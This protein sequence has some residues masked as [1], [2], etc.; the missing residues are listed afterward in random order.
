MSVKG[1]LLKIDIDGQDQDWATSLDAV[2]CQLFFLD[3]PGIVFSSEVGL[4]DQR[5][6]GCISS[7]KVV[8]DP[9]QPY[10]CQLTYFFSGEALPR[11]TGE[12]RNEGEL[13]GEEQDDQ[14]A[15]LSRS[16]A[17]RFDG[18]L[19]LANGEQFITPAAL[20]IYKIVFTFLPECVIEGKPARAKMAKVRIAIRGPEPGSDIETS[21]EAS[22]GE[23][24]RRVFVF[25]DQNF[26]RALEVYRNDSSAILEAQISYVMEPAPGVPMHIDLPAERISPLTPAI[27]LSPD[28]R[29]LT[30]KCDAR[31][32]EWHGDDPL[33]LVLVDLYV[34]DALTG[35]AHRVGKD[36][37]DIHTIGFDPTGPLEAYR[38]TSWPRDNDISVSWRACYYFSSGKQ[39]EISNPPDEPLREGVL[40][41]P[42]VP[43]LQAESATSPFV[44]GPTPKSGMDIIS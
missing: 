22:P 30:I 40:V 23:M 17:T 29:I 15:V 31:N 4:T 16:G 9:G 7:D 3:D 20:L 5:Q 11:L 6:T 35:L 25:N 34:R 19:T 13:G 32:V 37:W 28:L 14:G 18:P 1:P 2:T 21:E 33:A 26:T 12:G 41:L 24:E 27:Y 42:A 39:V 36:N 43:N 38:T 8:R 10:L 44:E